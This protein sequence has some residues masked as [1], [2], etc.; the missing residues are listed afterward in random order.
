LKVIRGTD[1]PSRMNPDQPT[2]GID[3][4]QF[5][6][7]ELSESGQKHW[8]QIRPMLVKAG[9]ATNLDRNALI[10][11]CEEWATFL[12]ATAAVRKK[13]IL[14]QGPKGEPM[15]NPYLRVMNESTAALT[16]L[17]SEFG[18]TPSSRTR[19]KG[20]TEDNPRGGSRNDFDG[21]DD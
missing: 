12:E 8:G 6:P 5:I 13:G 3:S 20:S 21:I 9:I 1:Q 2:A 14:V 16:R 19:L 4:L 18:M 17:L 10:L 11:L 15:R 7:S